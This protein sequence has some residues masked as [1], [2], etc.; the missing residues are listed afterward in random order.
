SCTVPISANIAFT[1]LFLFSTTCLRTLDLNDGDSYA[2]Y[3]FACE[4]CKR[5]VL[6]FHAASA[7]VVF[8]SLSFCLVNSL[9]PP[10]IAA[11]FRVFF[12]VPR[13]PQG[14]YQLSYLL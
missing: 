11:S 7:G 13:P 3:R 2:C 9:S 4:A 6:F 1:P 8:A 12:L 5:R 10:T 14:K